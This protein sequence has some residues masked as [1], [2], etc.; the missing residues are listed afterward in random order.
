MNHIFFVIA[1]LSDLPI[2]KSFLPERG[3]GGGGRGKRE[4]KGL[5]EK[6]VACCILDV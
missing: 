5:I 1:T 4:K 3:E 6:E 2:Q